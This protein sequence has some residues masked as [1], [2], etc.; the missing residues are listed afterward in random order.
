[1]K[2]KLHRFFTLFV[3]IGLCISQLF[4]V[5]AF[6][7]WQ[8]RTLTDGTP[9][10]VRLV[11][12]EFY[13]LWETEDGK[14]A[15]MQED[16]TFVV[17]NE[18][19]P[20]MKQVSER[21]QSA[22]AAKIP[23][24]RIQKNY[25]DIQPTKLLVILVNFSDKS[26]K[27]THNN[28]FFDNLLNG[29]FP[30]VK[31][32]FKQ[33]SGNTYVPEFDVFGPYT[34]DQNMAYYGGNDSDGSD[35]H[36]D[37]MVVDACAKAYA[38]G[39]D[40]SQYD[41][42]N[43]GK[44]DNIYVIYAGYGEAAGAPANTIWPHSW[45]IYSGNVTGTLKYNNKTLVH[46]ACS[47][48]LSG[49]SG[50]NSDGV[51]T[52][53]HEFSH[54]IGLPDYYD[55]DYGTN[56][57]NGVTPG[58]WTLMDQGSYNGSGMYPPLYSVYDKYFMG[59]MTP[60]FLAKDEV[61]NVTLT[62]TWNDNYQIT[63][64]ASLVACTNTSTVYYLENRQ[65]S[66][67][68]QYLPGHGM[69]VWKVTYNATR[70]NNNDL[71]N[72]AGTLR[73]TIVPADGKTKNYGAATDPFPGTGGKKIYTPATGCALSDIT[74]SSGNISFK[75]N[76]GVVK[77]TWDYVLAGEHC[78]YPADGEITKDAALNLTITPNSGY[79]LDDAA[80]WEVTMGGTKLT[81]GTDFTY[82]AGTNKFTI[83]SVT[84]DVE[85][86]VSAGHPVN[87]YAQ[88]TKV[89][90]NVAAEGKISLPA[91]PSNCSDSRQ[92]VGWCTNS[93]YKS[94]DTPPTYAK[95]GDAYSVANYY[96]VY[97]DV[98]GG[99]SASATYTFS[100]KSWSAS[101]S[102][103]VSSK[104]GAG[105]INSGV[106]VT[107]K[108]TGANAT[109]PSSYS[110]ISSIVVSYCTNAS[111]GAGSI[112]M[113]VDGTDVSESVT[114]SGGTTPR[115]LEFDFSEN[116]STG[117]PK[118]TVNCSTNS[119]Y[120]CGVTI[121]YG[122]ASYSGF[123]TDCTA[124]DPCAL[125]SISLNTS[126]VKTAF[127][128]G[129]VFTSEGLVV[130]ANYSNCSSK[131]VT[132]TS[133]STPDMSS[134][135]SKT[136]TV[137]YTENT[138]TK[139][140]TYNITV[141]APTTY[142]IRFFDGSTKLKEES[143]IMGATATPPT[144]DDCD[145]YEFIG[146]H[147]STLPTSNTT[148]YT[149]I[150]DF[151][152]SG[153][154][155]YYAVFSHTEG[156]G[157]GGS[158]IVSDEL[159]R[160]TTG[161][162]SGSTSYSSWSGKTATSD[163]VYAG[164]SAGGNNAI[165]LRTT[166]SNSG[167]ITTA[168]GGKVKKVTVAWNSNT[169]DGRTIDIYGKNSAYSAA[170]ELYNSSTSGTSLGSIV[171]GTSTE[172]SI[173][174]DY[175]YIGIRSRSGALYLSS[176][177][178]D[179]SVSGGSSS[180]TYY[181]TTKDCTIPTEVTVKFDAN[182]GE[183]IMT[184]QTIDYNTAT[185][186]KANSFERTGYTFLGW[187]TT[188]D[189]AKVY[190]DEEEV[191]LTQKT[192]T[193]YAV[194]KKN[195][196][197]VYF[198][199]PSGATVV[200]AN[201]ATESPLTV[202]YGET[203][204]IV[205]TPDAEHT[206]S[207]VTA[208]GDAV[209]SGEGNTRTFTMPDADVAISITMAEKPTYAVNFIN[210]GETISSQSVI[211]G[212][213]AVKPSDPEA[214][215]GYDFVGWW[216]DE[217]G[218]DNTTAETWI[219]TFTATGNQDYYAVYSPTEGSSSAPRR[220][221]MADDE[222][223]LYSGALTEGDYLIVYDGGAMNT[224]VSS[225]RLGYAEVTITNDKISNSNASIVWHLAASGNYWTLYNA[226]ANSYA[227]GTGAKN[228]AQM[229][230]DGTDNKSLW[231]VSGTSTYNFVNKANA[232]ANVNANLR[233][234][235]TYGFACYAAETGGELSL[236][237]K[238]G[239]GSGGGSTTIY[240][241]DPACT[242]CED[243]VTLEKG[244]ESHGTFTLDKVDGAYNNC[245][246]DFVVTVSDIE[247]AEGYRFV[248]VTATG[249]N[250]VVGGP[251][252]SGNYTVTYTKGNNITSTVTANFEVIPSHNVTWNVN[253]DDSNTDS[254]Q[255]GKA[256]V[257]PETA[258]GC[259]GKVFVGW[260]A[261]EV[262][263]TDVAP[264]FTS[265]ALM[266]DHDVTYYAV[267][268]TAS[269]SGGGAWDG[270]TAGT[271][272]IYASVDD[273]KYY[274]TG[275][276]SK[277]DGST[278]IND[279]ADYTFEKVTGGW[280]IKTGDKYITY[281]SK[282][283]LGT[284]GS[285]YTW[286]LSSGV[287]GTWRITA[288]A[289]SARGWIYRAGTSN[290]FGGYATSNVTASGTE[291]YDLEI[292]GGGGTSYSGYTTSCTPCEN[293]VTL[294]KGTSLN[295]TFALDKAD[296]EY[297]NCAV[298][299]LVVHV[300]DI[301]PSE[302]YQFKEIT[303]AGIATGVTIDNNAKTVTYDK[304][305]AGPSTINVVFEPKPSYTIR[306]YNGES[307]IGIAQTVVSGKTP[308]VPSN[309]EACEG[310]TFVGWWTETLAANNTETH[311]WVT[312]FTATG[313]RDYY[314]IYRHN[315]GGS[316]SGTESVT[317][318]DIYTSNTI[319]EDISIAIGTHTSVTFTKGGS[320]TQ[321][322]TNGDAIRWY[323]GGTCVVASDAG[324]ITGIIFTFGSSD[325]S[326]EIEA[327]G[328]VEPT[329]TG[330]ASSVTFTQSG[331]SGNRRIAGISVTVDG[332]G[333]AH[334]T[335]VFSCS[336]H[337]ITVESV[338]HGS[339]ASDKPRCDE[340]GTVT[341]TLTA[342]EGYDCGGITTSPVVS[343]TK[344]AECTYT[345]T[346]PDED[347]IVT[348]I[349]TP[350]TPRIF[351]FV[352]GTGTCATTSMTEAVWHG[353][354]T[355]PVATANSG[356]D[357]EY[358]FAGWATS[359][360][361]VETEV[362]PTLYA[363]GTLYNGEETT[364]YAVYSQTTGGSASG[365]T[366][367]YTYNEI[368]Y[369]VAAR[370]GT[371][372]YMG[373]STDA[374]EAA[375]FTIVTSNDKKYLCW[376]GEHDTYVH[377][378]GSNTTLKFTTELAN[379]SSWEV[380][381][382]GTSI[383]LQA[384]S[385]RYFMFNINQKDRFSTYAAE[386][387][388]LTKGDAGTTVYNSIPSCVCYS[389]DI[390][391]N[392]NGGTLAEGCEN[393]TG[394]ECERDWLLCDAPTREG[395]LFTNWKDQNGTLYDAGAVVTDLKISLTLT[396]QWIPAPYTVLFNAGSGSCVESL[397]ES[398]RGDGIILPKAEPSPACADDWTFIGWSET[399][400]E[401]ETN[402]SA[403]IIGVAGVAY[404]PETNNVTLYA[405]YSKLDEGSA[406]SDY[407]H[408]TDATPAEGDYAIVVAQGDESFG[409]LTYGTIA[410]GRLVYTKAY[411][412]LPSTPISS[413]EATQ[414]WHLTY[415]ASGNAY[416]YNAN[417]GAYLAASGTNITYDANAGSAFVFTKYP[418]TYGDYECLNSAASTSS[419][420]YLGANKDADYIRY[421]GTTTLVA[422]N[423]ITLYKGSTGTR[424]YS[425][426]PACTPCTDP[427]W[428]FEMGT[429]V[430][431]TKGSEPFTNRVVK[432]YESSGT[433]TYSSTNE[434][435]ATVDATG[436]VTMHETG[437][438]TI[439]LR[440]TKAMPYCAA[441]LQYEL[442]VKEPSIDIVGVTPDGEII[443]EHD[444]EGTIT[445]DLSEGNAISTGTAAN[446]L[447]FSKYFEAASNMKLF[448]IFNGT[449]HEMDLSNIRVRCNCTTDGKW[450][451]K[452]G[453]L[454]YVELRTISKLREQY[455]KLKIPS[456]TELIFW[457][458]NTTTAPEGNSKLR[459]CISVKIGD[460][461]YTYSDMEAMEIPNWFCL[462][463]HT[464]YNVIDADGNNQFIFNGDDSMILERYNPAT[465]QWEAIDIFGAGTSAAPA[466]TAGLVEKITTNYEINGS[467]QPLNDDPGFHAECEGNPIPLSTNR[468][469]LV[470]KNTVL[471]GMHAVASNTTSFSTLCEEWHGTPVGGAKDDAAFCHS[472]EIFSDIAE[473]DYAENYIDWDEI[474][475]DK[476]DVDENEDGTVSVTFTGLQDLAERACSLL[477]IEVHDKDDDT[478]ILATTEYKI[479][480]VVKEGN[481]MTTAELFH[482]QAEKCATCD[483][484]ILGSAIL[485]KATDGATND[486]PEVRD[487]YVY[488]GGKLVI[489]S[490]THYRA[491]DLIMRMQMADDKVNV[492]VPNVRVDGSLTNQYGGSIRQQVR[493]GT[494]RF[495]QFAV[496]YA[497]RLEDVTF[498][499]GT[500]AVYGEDFMIRFYDGEQRAANQ[501]TASNW[502]NFEGTQLMPG[503]GYTL[504]VAKKAGHEQ[505]ELIFPMADASLAEGEPATKATTIHAWGD[506]SIRA[507]HRGW[508][509]LSNPYLTT[510]GQNHLDEDA[511]GVLTTGR[512]VEDPKHPGWWISDED[513]IPY[514][515]L[516]NGT[517]TD[518]TQERVALQD[519]PPFTTF[520]I[521]A[522]DD[523]HS[524]GEE[525]SLTFN[526]DHRKA[527]APSYIRAAQKTPVA[528]FGVLLSGNGAEDNCGVVVGEKYSAAYDMQADLSKEFGSAYSL[529]LYSLQEDKMQMAF[530]ATHP[531]SLSQPIPLGVRL[532]ANGEYTFSIDRRY[533][534][535]AFAH[536]YLTDNLTGQHTDLL[537]DTYTFTGSRQQNDARFSLS[538]EM[539]KETPT[540]IQHLLN[541]VYAVGRDGS[542]LLTGM[543]ET[544]DI[545]IYDMGGRMVHS[546][547]TQ[548]ATSVTY[549]LPTGVYQ[550]R[551]LS[552]GA[553]ALLRTI[554]Y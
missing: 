279:A 356:C 115:D 68:D 135:G 97:A 425:T 257:F 99:G 107:A 185:A 415:D 388:S 466:S 26:M 348:P 329:W 224:T 523:D 491:R 174:G 396:A 200:T 13:H 517:R 309:P 158:S 132:P 297:E 403:T 10:R 530:L 367:S 532:P 217:L 205:I 111:S 290:Q 355:L 293:K 392:A 369:Y 483:V 197:N 272:K 201:G 196:W 516:I 78:T 410:K 212:Q 482:N 55:T 512:L 98:S 110:N 269:G 372:S 386:G 416:L 341:I 343:V 452:T 400:L 438:T 308:I 518:Y 211:E 280:A 476:Y 229:L 22:R 165:Q 138:V 554:V 370:S 362:R 133:V 118:I 387:G 324:N 478:K 91:A 529:K 148:S 263:E 393:V 333:T 169:A 533:N 258:S 336:G 550:I 431:K 76:G 80:C 189:G 349:F 44:V 407:T 319:V 243:K 463:N 525:F 104:D 429:S 71:N 150:S 88:G 346:M 163:A 33:S 462:G 103:W 294:T 5:P 549:P 357:P 252:G 34:L 378:S 9:I 289:N 291:Y 273:T 535:G 292:G 474:T 77:T 157:G 441:V 300:T 208:T 430:T 352:P 524:N 35:E 203:V 437:T 228:K 490:G 164:Q 83:T 351:T 296:G 389:V 125:T 447:F 521:Q 156:S 74:E 338:E 61:K 89:A 179:W 173:T 277:I 460:M 317:F 414:I 28:A 59:W 238:A 18:D 527:S 398:S 303:Q 100:D 507:N 547:H 375:R 391:Y 281:S 453:D 248:N 73:Y 81:Y 492:E 545:Y 143:L 327:E 543:P 439:T 155:N 455:P 7:G 287:K 105:Y 65:K 497:V 56:S 60:K 295:G 326:N 384:S 23:A 500:P 470:R 79:S 64:G 434:A 286:E 261:T 259:E 149:W 172:L 177:T 302:D 249:G 113:T 119:I 69:V 121:T 385:G 553:N 448:A 477:K 298:G 469:M 519:L 442:E 36:P 432:G 496:P 127:T 473:Y 235:G 67:Y 181:T 514:V 51:G 122:S 239:S 231:T 12:D 480:I 504:A 170:T 63:G 499:D 418:G 444:L 96:A 461:T 405:V 382:E 539:Q 199:T 50:S 234:N 215:E 93:T 495:Y 265:S 141:S 379:A 70:W 40:F 433:V 544:A 368:T 214:C 541:G 101:P 350:K 14:I 526:R 353:G 283:D 227:A 233:K 171:K 540:D 515:T 306:F 146:W 325:G 230:A 408:V 109:C 222:Y 152:V 366:L 456:G 318:S 47:A 288:G 413:P 376:H 19:A 90:T 380:T 443:L 334:Y 371:N 253:G 52:F 11:G 498:S 471:D 198:T 450:P 320:D 151:T 548:G 275:T 459:N 92:F 43:D 262:A 331:T 537:D 244:A 468:Y 159:T 82:N 237:K 8:E 421:Y 58:E 191:T 528:R 310:Y 374:A 162:T 520:F 130:T 301:T 506:N 268:A 134:I 30:S 285:A 314:A 503:V 423:C 457:S 207:A 451:K 84:G 213:T 168:S 511:G 345:F 124:P 313:N 21:R 435:V 284:S 218:T 359:A 245:T 112:K 53:A 485:T 267:F 449:G 420:Y 139:S 195:S 424:Y 221:K 187:A 153:V 427:E 108:S 106:Q 304:D 428:S 190:D 216:T 522:G 404:T 37:Q 236:Y 117:T 66:G 184:D 390:T 363:A 87:W 223:E 472:G 510:Y 264:A 377:N 399:N 226:D 426:S 120:I 354:V 534:L 202:E 256:I 344:T 147:T 321:Y 123:S 335:S 260:S 4:A 552:E 488:G 365:F 278:D 126:G 340:G 305:V 487:I 161:V 394:G 513:I 6:R 531:D 401:G 271:Y 484:A 57:D 458:N 254:Y 62:T 402:T 27:S 467:V 95:T 15:T 538:V 246:S 489:P 406:T 247:A 486:M 312:D 136:V 2:N 364:L 49:K 39:C 209:L 145:E 72:T 316:G 204:T 186:L 494:S 1:M 45:E 419:N 241:T 509:F 180:T 454:G 255:E 311:T 194:W 183:G 48:E 322:Y 274:A 395:Y 411:T 315:E 242:P 551:V 502:R 475:D 339:G 54:V 266:G 440:L 381:E 178:I 116:T 85:I 210:M 176:V 282:T 46:Y 251:D 17:S 129:E 493:V 361:T 412:S 41:T 358:V 225:G 347:L 240:T 276:G 167:I 465:G 307:L 417:A 546:G 20:S 193:L 220:A 323:G 38:D 128:T 422:T 542:L 250:N 42:N 232:A 166:N 192:T 397:T 140:T 206:I 505:R 144:V 32:Y 383:T 24:S 446:D 75:Y 332:G 299:G 16:G 154:Q 479:P 219:T 536:I 409:L 501:G 464:T 330:E 102:N 436:L 94:A 481:V 160:A 328:Y 142:A 114:S 342:D 508:N 137:T 445:L 86:I 3:V 188:T 175:E 270:S 29:S 373:A 337:M 31:D 360:V 25:G 182:G 131:T